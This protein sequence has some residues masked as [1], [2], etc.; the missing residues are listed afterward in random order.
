MLYL[1]GSTGRPDL[2]HSSQP[3]FMAY[4]LLKPIFINPRATRALVSSWGQSQYRIRVFSLGKFSAQESMLRFGSCLTEPGI[5]ALTSPVRKSRMTTSGFPRS[6]ETCSTPS[7]GTPREC[8]DTCWLIPK[9]PRRSGKR[10]RIPVSPR[11][12]FMATSSTNS[13]H[14]SPQAKLP[15]HIKTKRA[16]RK[17]GQRC[18]S[19]VHLGYPGST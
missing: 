9:D 7:S 15:F 6:G 17:R 18:I 1:S 4:T 19:H 3:P 16:R 14:R 10:P 11:Q 13:L 12:H 8:A 2:S 5:F